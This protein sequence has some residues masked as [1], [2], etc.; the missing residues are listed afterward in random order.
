MTQWL[1]ALILLA[2]VTGNMSAGVAVHSGQRGCTRPDMPDCCA[3]ARAQT[4]LPIVY[5]ARLCCAVNCSQP[6]TPSARCSFGTPLVGLVAFDDR[7]APP[8]AIPI[9]T[10]SPRF[11][12]LSCL[13]D[14][15]PTYLRHLALLI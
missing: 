1:T 12:P 8:A 7:T 11:S 15:P 6:A 5:A 14:S 4:D 13:G 9:L 10:P 2:V 3:T